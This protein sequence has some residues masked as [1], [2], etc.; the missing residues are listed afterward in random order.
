MARRKKRKSSWFSGYVKNFLI[1]LAVGGL[2]WFV[3][4]GVKKILPKK[5]RMSEKKTIDVIRDLS[6]LFGNLPG[7]EFDPMQSASQAKSIFDDFVLGKEDLDQEEIHDIW[8]DWLDDQDVD[9]Q[10]DELV[11]SL[12]QETESHAVL[13]DTRYDTIGKYNAIKRMQYDFNGHKVTCFLMSYFPSG[14]DTAVS[15]PHSVFGVT[16][17]FDS[18][19]LSNL[20]F[21]KVGGRL[22]ITKPEGYAPIA[23]QKVTNEWN[24][25]YEFPTEIGDEMW[26]EVQHFRSLGM[27]RSFLL[28]G[29]PG[30]GKTTFA[31]EFSR[32]YGNGKVVSFDKASFALLHSPELRNLLAALSPDV[33]VIDD[34]DRFASYQDESVFL[35]ILEGIKT[36]DKMPVFFATANDYHELSMAA[37]RPGRFDEIYKFGFPTKEQRAK[38]I[39]NLIKDHVAE[40]ALEQTTEALAVATTKMTHSYIRHYCLQMQFQPLEKVLETIKRRKK[41]FDHTIEIPGSKSTFARRTAR[42]KSDR[43][44]R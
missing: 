32:R 11:V 14:F 39:T 37:R 35:K 1:Q 20:I 7:A 13:V 31:L 23:F 22:A 36:L 30:T 34:I 33:I 15:K 29:P 9:I 24:P 16:K 41:Y 6:S 26:K 40:D 25:D 27:Q 43:S 42:L 5:W 28:E 19:F 17:G 8:R 44:G 18:S 4:Y 12:F 10:E 21:D 3:F 38:M 2:L